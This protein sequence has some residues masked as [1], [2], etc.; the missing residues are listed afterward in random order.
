MMPF[1]ADISDLAREAERQLL[2]DIEIPVLVVAVLSMA[3][4]GFGRKELV[5]GHKEW[6]DGVGEVRNVSVRDC[7]ARDRALHRIAEIVVLVRAIIHAKAGADNGRL[8]AEE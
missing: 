5:L 3:V 6:S 7:V 8:V 1:A 2:L 4:D